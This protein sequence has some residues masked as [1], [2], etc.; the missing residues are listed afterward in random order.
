MSLEKELK[1]ILEGREKI[2]AV[3]RPDNTD[4]KEI[5]NVGRP[6]SAEPTSDKSTYTR[7]AEIYRKVIEDKETT[8]ERLSSQ[9]LFE[10]VLN[11]IE[12]KKGKTEV[13]LNPKT[14]PSV[15]DGEDYD[16]KKKPV[17]ESSD[18][19][20]NLATVNRIAGDLKAMAKKEPPKKL[21]HVNDPG[22]PDM[23][24]VEKKNV[25]EA[26][27]GGQKKLDVAAPKGKLTSADFKKLRNEEVEQIDELTGKGQLR[28]LMKQYTRERDA[29]VKD[30]DINK[31]KD[32][33]KKVT[34]ATRMYG[35][36]AALTAAKQTFPHLKGKIKDPFKGPKYKKTVEET[37]VLDEKK[38]NPYAVGM[39]QAMKASGDEPPL[40][41]STIVKAHKIAKAVKREDV[42][43]SEEEI[44][45][46]ANFLESSGIDAQEKQSNR[47][48]LRNITA[49]NK[50][51]QKEKEHEA[52][53]KEAQAKKELVLKQSYEPEN[54]AMIEAVKN[55]I[56]NLMKNPDTPFTG[57][58]RGVKAKDAGLTHITDGKK[59]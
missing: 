33:D 5:E 43:F 16:K 13:D 29:A 46:I 19:D 3:P 39:A 53:A 10:K 36:N 49:A 18:S 23:F 15:M 26:L 2:Q 14:N 20:A 25:K 4:R 47:D 12:E 42:N 40:K 34:R 28:P 48:T 9:K 44:E 11:V 58:N 59:K 35:H 27:K 32:I 1:S 31:A 52:R 38:V 56:Q 57:V 51:K 17:K 54:D 50:K 37:E 24:K 55:S 21:P 7:T 45:H 30:K 41:K 22:V 6:D 8:M